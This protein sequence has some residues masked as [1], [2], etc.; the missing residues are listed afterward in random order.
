FEDAGI[1]PELYPMIRGR[2]VS[3]NDRP[4]SPQ[5]YEGDRAQRLVEREFNLSYAAQR[6]E[7]NPLVGGQW[8]SGGPEVSVEQGIMDTLGL[9]L[10]DKLEFDIAGEPVPA[11]I[12]SV[13][14]VA[15]DSMKVNFFM[16]L[17]P[18]AVG[19]QPRTLITA[20]HQPTGGSASPGRQD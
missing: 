13:R 2:L 5:D 18:E 15:W 9:A 10:G 6:P 7:H 14:R 11:R 3:I 12:T 8:F 19:D 20:Y 1:R 4:V 17:S 16:I